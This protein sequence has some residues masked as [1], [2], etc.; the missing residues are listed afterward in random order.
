MEF[1]FNPDGWDTVGVYINPSTGQLIIPSDADIATVY[2]TGLT[3]NI[4]GVPEP[5]IPGAVG[6]EGWPLGGIGR[7]PQVPQ[8]DLVPLATYLAQSSAKFNDIPSLNLT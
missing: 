7:F 3:A 6:P 5:S 8:F 1:V 2:N 4:E